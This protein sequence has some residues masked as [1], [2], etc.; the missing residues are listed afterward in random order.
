MWNSIPL[1]LCATTEH[2][3]MFLPETANELRC[4]KEY[5][6]QTF[7]LIAKVPEIAGDEEHLSECIK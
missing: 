7:H 3:E 1:F 5:P 4:D 2:G 6:P